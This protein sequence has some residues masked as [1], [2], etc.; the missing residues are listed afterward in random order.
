MYISVLIILVFLSYLDISQYKNSKRLSQFLGL[1]AA[2]VFSILI[3][4]RWDVG[5]DYM[6]YYYFAVGDYAYD[7]EINRLEVIPRYL[8]LFTSKTSV[9]F[10]VWF[11]IM[12]FFQIFF[13]QN[14]LKKVYYPILGWGVFFFIT[15]FLHEQMNIVR[16]GAAICIVLFSY[17]YILS[18]KPLHYIICILF[19]YL[20]HKSAIIALPIYLLGNIE[21]KISAKWQF[22]IVILCSFLSSI[23]ISKILPSLMGIAQSIGYGNAM[24]ILIADELSTEKGS[25][26]GILYYYIRY[27]ILISCYPKLSERYKSYGFNFFYLLSFIYLCI[28]PAAFYSIYIARIFAYFKY[29]DLVTYAF[30]MHYLASKSKVS[31]LYYL[32]VVLTIGQILL[33][34]LS[35]EQW[36]FVWNAN[37]II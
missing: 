6:A 7:Y 25:G 12:A 1:F 24:E 10:Y 8:A 33:Y 13:V 16:Q 18:K 5:V 35:G 9:P 19:A 32:M 31:V 3:G 15:L 23:A 21:I 2:L 17:Q 34:V 11:I 14:L 20:F 28:Y 29:C 36:H 37:L 27:A 26:I 22:V 4:L 30:L